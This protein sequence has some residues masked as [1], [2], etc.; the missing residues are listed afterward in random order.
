MKMLSQKI[1]SFPYTF[2][3]HCFSLL[4]PLWNYWSLLKHI[5]VEYNWKS[6]TWTVL[7]GY[8]NQYTGLSNGLDTSL[9]GPS[10]TKLPR[11]NICRSTILSSKT[12]RQIWHNHPFSQRNKTTKE[13]WGGV[14][15]SGVDKIWKR[16]VGNIGGSS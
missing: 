1:S 7:F 15:K 10:G 13:Q 5:F 16:G 2:L 8:P 3:S 14:E 6:K 4:S 12:A 11:L 9:Q